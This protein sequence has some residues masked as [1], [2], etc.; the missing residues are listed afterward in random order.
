MRFSELASPKQSVL[1]SC[2]EEDKDNIITLDWHMPVSIAPEL[3]AI[4]VGKTRYSLNLIRSSR[5][6]VVNYMSIKREKEVLFC[7]AHSGLHVNKFKE[8]SFTKEEA[9]TIDCARIKEACA[10][11]E[12]EVVNEIEAGD[13]I[14]FVAKVTHSQ[15]NSQEP[16]ILHVRGTE[17]KSIGR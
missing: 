2:R 4:S 11:L 6:F 3:Y 1:V 12:C 7:G 9:S 5:C 14:I 16:R 17:F 10:H 15:E 13:H 8:C